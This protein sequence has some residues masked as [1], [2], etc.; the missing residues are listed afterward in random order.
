MRA[1]RLERS[2][3]SSLPDE[4]D[5]H[6]HEHEPQQHQRLVPIS[7]RHVARAAGHPQEAHR[8]DDDVPQETQH[9]AKPADRQLVG[10]ILGQAPACFGFA[11]PQAS[12][13]IG[14][15]GARSSDGCR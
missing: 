1:Q 7:Q 10:A 15:N 11:Q 13:G 14:S 12:G 3:R 5:A 9:A 2:F 6:H 8:L 4:G